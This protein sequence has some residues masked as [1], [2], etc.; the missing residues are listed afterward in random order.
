MIPNEQR[1][2]LSGVFSGATRRVKAIFS[3]SG[4]IS[5]LYR[6]SAWCSFCLARR[7]NGFGSGVQI[8]VKMPWNGYNHF[9]SGVY[10][11]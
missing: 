6:L 11:Q 8:K 10:E 9:G 4:V 7:N 1:V 5:R 3:S 2:T